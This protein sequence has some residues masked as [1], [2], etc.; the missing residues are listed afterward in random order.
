MMSELSGPAVVAV[1]VS[2]LVLVLVAAA[3][4]LLEQ[5]AARIDNDRIDMMVRNFLITCLALLMKSVVYGNHYAAVSLRNHGEQCA[6]LEHRGKREHEN[7]TATS[8]LEVMLP[9][10]PQR[11][12]FRGNEIDGSC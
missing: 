7:R 9:A 4:S 2:V 10:P 11:E 8:G 12:L 5:P 6:T 1:L 3:L